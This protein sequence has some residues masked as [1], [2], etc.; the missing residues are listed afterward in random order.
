MG[1]FDWYKPV[2]L[3]NCPVCGKTLSEWQGKDADCLLFV[4]Q[5]G[6]ANPIEHKG[7]G[8]LES[9]HQKRRIIRQSRN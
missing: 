6:L 3:L 2:P 9:M 5:Q 7:D 4:W 8:L 1:M